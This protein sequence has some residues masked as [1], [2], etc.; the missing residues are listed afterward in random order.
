M[1]VVLPVGA[2]HIR[3]CACNYVATVACGHT[4]VSSSQAIKQN[5]LHQVNNPQKTYNI[6]DMFK[7]AA[8]E[9]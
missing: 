1:S 9:H 8:L 5:V 2:V 7:I 3:L 4:D 6:Q